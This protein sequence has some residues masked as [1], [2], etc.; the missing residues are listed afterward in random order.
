MPPFHYATLSHTI[1]RVCK[2]GTPSK[3]QHS[4]IPPDATIWVLMLRCWA[5]EPTKRPTMKEVYHT[6]ISIPLHDPPAG[7]PSSGH[8][9]LQDEDRHFQ[10]TGS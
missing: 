6:V 9:Q 3:D 1:A 5:L 7:S 10:E 2:G 8:G 4:K